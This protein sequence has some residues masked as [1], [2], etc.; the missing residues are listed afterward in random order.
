MAAR[1][2]A[3]DPQPSADTL[4]ER[5]PSPFRP[6]TPHPLAERA[7][8][9]LRAWLE[10]NPEALDPAR[11]HG[12]F[13]GK[14]FG[15]L[16]VREA[17]GRLG[18]LQGFAGAFGDRRVVEGFAPP[19]YD[20]PAFEALWTGG[21]ATIRAWDRRIAALRPAV[22]AGDPRAAA[23]LETLI[24]AQRSY[25]QALHQDIYATYRIVN[26]RGERADLPALFAP[27]P[28]PGGAGDCAGPK[29]LAAALAMELTP[30]AMAEFWWG[31]PPPAGGR[32]HGVYYPACRG[33]CAKLLPFML[34]GVDCEP[35][36][37]VGLGQVP[38]D[39]PRVVYEDD[40][41]LVV[42]KPPGMLSVP[43]RGPRRRD[44]VEYRLKARANPDTI[45]AAVAAQSKAKPPAGSEASPRLDQLWPRLVHRL[46]L[47][48]SGLLIAAKHREAYVALQRQ[49][50]S[51]QIGKR[52]VAL[53]RGPL[54]DALG[55][56]G[57]IELPLARDLDDR[58]RQKVD[59]REGKVARTRWQLLAHAPEQ[60]ASRVAL[61]PH[62]GR[63]HQLRLH[64][65]HP[66]GLDAPLVGDLL[67]GY[68]EGARLMLH[69]ERLTFLHPTRGEP[70]EL[71]SPCPF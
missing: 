24:L 21:S 71:R 66:E 49:F 40:D 65:A 68:G 6:G 56:G 11:F 25:S 41:L 44:S 28:P 47:A 48:T 61:Y 33:R 15:V 63:T 8:R 35:A 7:A 36:P 2:I 39:A 46:D 70:M 5:F 19:T 50:S 9:A 62:T 3:F 59:H 31:G 26:A 53:V 32:Q 67:Y 42:D 30:V 60:A 22:E 14:M 4:P 1:F 18:Y 43:G 12:R 17:S 10:A 27:L 69:A 23:E 51:R 64:A 54:P 29:L 57:E 58:P 45:E 38:D 20:V 34:E 52:Y 55:E 16:V 13:G 37:D